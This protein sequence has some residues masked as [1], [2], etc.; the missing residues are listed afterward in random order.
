MEDRQTSDLA[1]EIRCPVDTR[2]LP[3]IRRFVVGAAEQMGFDEDDTIKIEISV[4]EACANVIRHAY[5][6]LDAAARR[7]HG[8]RVRMEQLQARLRI[9]VVDFG[10]GARLGRHAGVPSLEAYV[11]SETP[12]GLGTYIMGQLMDEVVFHFPPDCGT[13]VTLVKNLPLAPWPASTA[14]R[15]GP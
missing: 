8:I 12:R 1:L 11:R 15:P 5:S 2:V 10:I 13:Q 14:G 7:K 6:R 3:L 9:T 4:D